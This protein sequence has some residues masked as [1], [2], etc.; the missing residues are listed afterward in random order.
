MKRQCLIFEVEKKEK[1]QR[2][3]KKNWNNNQEK[4][5]VQ[6]GTNKGPWQLAKLQGVRFNLQ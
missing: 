4:K 5:K 1:P 2:R 6:R 3:W